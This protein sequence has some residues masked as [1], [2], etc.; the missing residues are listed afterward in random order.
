MKR[1]TRLLSGTALALALASAPAAR[2]G[3]AP[4]AAIQGTWAIGSIQADSSYNVGAGTLTFDGN[5]G[6]TG[7]LSYN[8]DSEYCVNMPV[9]GTYNVNPGK[10]SATATMT[11]TTVTTGTCAGLG[12]DETLTLALSLGNNFKTFYFTE[13]DPK[14]EGNF[15]YSEGYALA[16]VGT[17]F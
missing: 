5:G 8:Y 10:L 11:V 9:S 12:D 6:V 13:I 14:V 7:F 16:G 17:H 15:I 2:A 1:T 4:N 3:V